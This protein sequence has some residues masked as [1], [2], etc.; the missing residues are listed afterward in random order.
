MPACH[1]PFVRA[2]PI[3]LLNAGQ[4]GLPFRPGLHDQPGLTEG[5]W[6][7][8]FDNGI[9]VQVLEL[10]FA[11]RY[12][13]PHWNPLSGGRNGLLLS[14]ALH[15]RKT[16]SQT[17]RL[18]EIRGSAKLRRALMRQ[19]QACFHHKRAGR[20]GQRSGGG[21]VPDILPPHTQHKR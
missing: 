21:P 17:M 12:F 11:G 8:T 7:E 4:V 19:D 10:P 16:S 2:S 3:A 5:T 15:T 13:D 20:R 14:T 9:V 6:P 18:N 1:Q